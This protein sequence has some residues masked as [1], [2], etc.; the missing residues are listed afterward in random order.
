MVIIK[1]AFK[2]LD[3]DAERRSGL[4]WDLQKSQEQIQRQR[5]DEG[6]KKPGHQ[7][8]N[9]LEGA[10]ALGAWRQ[11]HR[12]RKIIQL[13]MELRSCSQTNQAGR[14]E[15]RPSQPSKKAQR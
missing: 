7:G 14:S 2:G 3:I 6:K 8:R 11:P 1:A 9:S 5:P 10:V 4:M 15:R 12:K 13:Q